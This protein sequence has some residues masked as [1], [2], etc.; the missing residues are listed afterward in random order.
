MALRAGPSSVR[1]G[2][3]FWIVHRLR[4]AIQKWKLPDTPNKEQP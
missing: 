2:F 3:H 4:Y 1:P